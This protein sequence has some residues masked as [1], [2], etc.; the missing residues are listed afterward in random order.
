MLPFW[1]ALSSAPPKHGAPGVESRDR[2][3]DVTH[4]ALALDLDPEERR[5]DGSVTLYVEPL[6]PPSSELRLDQVG[7][8]IQGVWIDDQEQAFRADDEHLHIDLDPSG[9]H[10]VHVRYDAQPENGLHWRGDGPDTYSEVWSQGEGEDNRY[11]IPLWDHPNDRFTYSGV[12]TAPEGWQVL[13]NGL[14]G[15]DDLGAWSYEMEEDLVAY[16]IM[17][18]AA[19]YTVIKNDQ[20]EVPIEWWIPPDADARQAHNAAGNLPK[21]LEFFGEK[22]GLDYPYPIYREVYVQRFLYTGMENTT[23]TVMHRR[24]LLDDVLVSTRRGSESVVAHELA[25]QWYGDALTCRSWHELWLNEGF[26]TFFA[27]EWMRQVDGDEAWAASLAN[28]Y[29]HSHT[30]PLAGRWWS[31]PEGDHAPSSNVYSKGSSVLQMLRVML[32]EE[33]FWAGIERY[34]TENAHSMVETD[35]LRRAFEHTSGL[36]LRWFFDQW[37]HL[38]GGA[39]LEVSQ[40]FSEGVLTIKLDQK[41]QEDRPIF[42]LPVDVEVGGAAEPVRRRVWMDSTHAELTIDLDE[43]PAYIAVDPDGGL[44]AHID[45]KQSNAMWQAQAERSTPYARV[46]AIEALAEDAENEP[47]LLA[48]AQ[49]TEESTALRIEAIEA[50]KHSAAGAEVA[51]LLS[52]ADDRVRQAAADNLAGSTAAVGPAL[53]AAWRS[54]TQPDVKAQVLRSLRK[55]DPVLARAEAKKWLRN[56]TGFHNPVHGAA[57]GVLKR[58]AKPTDA[59]LVRRFVKAETAADLLHTAIWAA[60][61]IV[62]KQKG[63]E[64]TQAREDLARQLEPLLASADLRTRQTV[65]SALG[66]VGD[67]RTQDALKRYRKVTRLQSEKER[68]TSALD[69]IRNRKDDAEES[70]ASTAARLEKLEEELD[71]LREEL[72]AHS[73]RH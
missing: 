65:V 49:N 12:F 19:P 59:A 35:D 14:G 34:T 20:G 39:E 52:D 51:A 38:P 24:V 13:S 57:L 18:A 4:L 61:H 47:F 29:D 66:K 50:L 28:R 45:V 69:A 3:W 16:L 48:I 36:H 11:W 53:A 72:D 46:R 37:V 9:P 71:A 41:E 2:H 67:A 70:E 10:K 26:A 63:E 73:A 5:I 58:E 33:A 55:H 17:V 25:H 7:L 40:S 30:G 32:G 1:I 43:A 60:V 56:R 23:S 54:E 27:S 64:R 44:L 15:R 31:T 62:E 21:M 8:N 22:T 6:Q 42:V 68:A